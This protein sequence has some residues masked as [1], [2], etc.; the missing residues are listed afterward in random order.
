MIHRTMPLGADGFA[1]P[2]SLRRRTRIRSPRRAAPEEP[3][4]KPVIVCKEEVTMG[5]AIYE[6]IGTAGE[7][8][9]KHERKAANVYQTKESAFEA[10]EPAPWKIGVAMSGRSRRS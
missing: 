7:W 9:V 10:A 2:E 1:S 8:R 5:Q 6:I 4:P 3:W